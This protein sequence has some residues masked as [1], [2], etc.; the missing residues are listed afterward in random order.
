MR[1]PG[2]LLHYRYISTLVVRFWKAIIELR[3]GFNPR[4]ELGDWYSVGCSGIPKLSVH[5]IELGELFGINLFLVVVPVTVWVC[6]FACLNTIVKRWKWFGPPPCGPTPLMDRP[7]RPEYVCR[8]PSCVVV[9]PWNVW[10][11]E[12]G[13]STTTSDEF[14]NRCRCALLADVTPDI[15]WRT[16]LTVGLLKDYQPPSIM[17]YSS[18]FCDCRTWH[19]HL[20]QFSRPN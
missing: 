20:E 6:P 12:P 3:S 13:T 16:R 18:I 2:L 9:T 8:C 14:R 1:S 5:K 17:W 15:M 10:K 19:R 4:P 7:V 11:C